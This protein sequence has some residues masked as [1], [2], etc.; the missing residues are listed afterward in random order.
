MVWL[1]SGIPNGKNQA[2]YGPADGPN[3]TLP[4]KLYVVGENSPS[5]PDREDP[6]IILDEAAVNVWA[7]NNGSYKADDEQDKRRRYER[8]PF[9]SWSYDRWTTH[10]CW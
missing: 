4:I 7:I 2:E 1:W 10:G 6:E 3:I 9:I 8:T 5:P